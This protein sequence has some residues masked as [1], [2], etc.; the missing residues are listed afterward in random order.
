MLLRKDCRR[1]KNR[2]LPSG[3][4]RAKGRP[5]CDLCLSESYIPNDEPIH[6]NG[7]LEVGKDVVDRTVDLLIIK[8]DRAGLSVREIARILN[9]PKST[10]HYRLRTIP[11]D[12]RDYSEGQIRRL[13]S[14]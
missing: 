3:L 10:I 1:N 6:R 2:N 8:F 4:D 14:A 7:I 13:D 11:P 9:R 12:A 5:Y